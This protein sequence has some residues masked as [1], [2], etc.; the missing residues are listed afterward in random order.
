MNWLTPGRDDAMS[1]DNYHRMDS[2][3]AY[4]DRFSFTFYGH[5]SAITCDLFQN[6]LPI[7]R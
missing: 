7:S 3:Y 2:I 4:I 1:W 5:M 6:V